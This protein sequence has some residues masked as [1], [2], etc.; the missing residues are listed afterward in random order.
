MVLLLIPHVSETDVW[1][2]LA[3]RA[4]LY[5]VVRIDP[6]RNLMLVKGPVPGH[7]KGQI[8]VRPAIRLNRGKA[9][10]ASA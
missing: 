3:A 6:E 4:P 7:N 10:K 8:Q 5:E 2:R 1:A 9:R